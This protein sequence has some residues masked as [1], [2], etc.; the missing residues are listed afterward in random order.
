MEAQVES[1]LKES[2]TFVE[3]TGIEQKVQMSQKLPSIEEYTQ[4]RMGSSAVGMC[5]AITEY[6]SPWLLLGTY[7]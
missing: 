1:F 6:A 3:M 2:I 4:R 5:L 7:R